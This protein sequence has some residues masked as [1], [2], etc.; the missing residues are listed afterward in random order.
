[1]FIGIIATL[2][3]TVFFGIKNINVIGNDRYTQSEISEAAAIK[4]GENLFRVNIK[5][6]QENILARFPYIGNLKI[7]RKLPIHCL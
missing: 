5:A 2:S 7:T 6:A 1:M 4:T 3:M